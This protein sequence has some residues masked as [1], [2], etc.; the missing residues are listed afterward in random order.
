MDRLPGIAAVALMVLGGVTASAAPSTAGGAP[1][2]IG[3]AILSAPVPSS[4]P[5]RMPTA[6]AP[7]P[8]PANPRITVRDASIKPAPAALP[9]P[10]RIRYPGINADMPVTAVGVAFD[11]AMEVPADAAVA[12]WYRYSAA[13]SEKSGSTIIAAHAGSIPTPRGPLYDLRSSR[14]GQE[15]EIVDTKGARTLWKV[16]RPGNQTVVFREGC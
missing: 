10:A 2:P 6:P 3:A 11:G 14:V 5:P 1:A 8:A 15:I 12:G 16:T 9:G 13:P 7:E 4:V